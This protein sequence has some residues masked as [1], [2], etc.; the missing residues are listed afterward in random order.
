MRN[1][2]ENLGATDPEGAL[3]WADSM[4]DDQMGSEARKTVLVQWAD[5]D[6]RAVIDYLEGSGDTAGLNEQAR[7]IAQ[8]LAK[9]DAQ[10]AALFALSLENSQAQ[11]A[12]IDV[13]TKELLNHDTLEA[14][15]WIDDLEAGP[16]R[17]KAVENLVNKMMQYDTAAAFIWGGTL[18]KNKRME[19]LP[20]VVGQMKRNGESELAREAIQSSDLPDGEKNKLLSQL[21]SKKRT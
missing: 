8:S 2:A 14:S 6:P 1:I 16:V 19:S 12:A 5:A 15:K 7:S 4:I 17:N 20:K 10:A 9:D 13:A 21:E 11:L 3:A 18:P